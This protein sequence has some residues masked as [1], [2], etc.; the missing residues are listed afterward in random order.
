M[1][2]D[3][4]RVVVIPDVGRRLRTAAL[5]GLL[6]PVLVGAIPTYLLSLLVWVFGGF[7]AAWH[8]ALVLTGLGLLVGLTFGGRWAYR[9]LNAIRWI[10]LRPGRVVFQKVRG[11]DSVAVSDLRSVHVVEKIKLGRSIGSEARFTTL[12]RRFESSPLMVP[13]ATLAERLGATGLEVT[14]ETV[15]ERAHLPIESWYTRSQVAAIWGV[16]VDDDLLAQLKVPGQ[17]YTPRIGAMHGVNHTR[18]VFN[19]DDVHLAAAQLPTG[20]SAGSPT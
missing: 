13:A 17:N 7:S 6:V 5:A 1:S 20:P 4:S 18:R 3:A 16:P 15:T 2:V 8:T 9:E 19:P 11:T 10:D 12:D 14:H